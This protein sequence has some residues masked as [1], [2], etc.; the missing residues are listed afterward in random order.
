MLKAWR[1]RRAGRRLRAMMRGYRRLRAEHRTDAVEKLLIKLEE[2]PLLPSHRRL[3]KLVTGDLDLP[4]SLVVQQYCAHR[5]FRPMLVARLVE[6]VGAPDR[7][8]RTPLPGAWQAALQGEGVRVDRLACSLLWQGYLLALLGYTW[9][10]AARRLRLGRG[11]DLSKAAYFSGLTAA[12]LPV[13]GAVG[14]SRDILSWFARKGP[15]PETT[16]WLAHSAA[17]PP[18]QH[19]PEAGTFPVRHVPGPFRPAPALR[20]AATLLRLTAASLGWALSGAWWNRVLVHEAALRSEVAS[21]APGDLAG[22]YAFHNSA[23]LLR[24]LWTYEAEQKG[25]EVQFYFYSS[26]VNGKAP[27]GTE[28]RNMQWGLCTWTRW[29]VWDVEMANFV[30]RRVGARCGTIDVVGPIDFSDSADPLPDIPTRSVAVF[31]VQPVRPALYA[32]LGLGFDYY[33]PEI[34]TAFLSEVT[35]TAGALQRGVVLKRKRAHGRNVIHRRYLDALNRLERGGNLVP[36]SPALAA[37]R[38]IERVDAVISA[39]FT[40]TGILAAHMG[41]PSCFYDPTGLIAAD[42]R[43]ARGLPVF[44]RPEQLATWLRGLDAG[45]AED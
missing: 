29:L 12:Q 36:A 3:S 42:D 1:V 27:D 25:A 11:P 26:F 33:R 9:M 16:A 10:D 37:S 18:G 35:A 13:A 20:A 38:L 8:L 32:G 4:E 17:V 23:W 43:D 30:R 44:H 7:P 19:V 2:T 22:S 6:Q 41:K 21:A 15:L 24:P 14:G 40:S 31:D 34:A 28:F 39:P 5:L 45:P